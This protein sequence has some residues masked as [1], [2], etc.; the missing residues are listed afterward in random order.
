[1][2]MYA[3]KNGCVGLGLAGNGTDPVIGVLHTG[4]ASSERIGT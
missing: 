1:M 4:T 2:R 3:V